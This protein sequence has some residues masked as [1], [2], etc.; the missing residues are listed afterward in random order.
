MKNYLITI[1]AGLPYPIGMDFREKATTPSAAVSRAMK[2]Y[3][4]RITGEKGRK[5]ISELNIKVIKI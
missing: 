1:T 5:I 4:E 2:K 3:R